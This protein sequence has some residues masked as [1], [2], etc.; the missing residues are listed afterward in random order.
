[1]ATADMNYDFPMSKHLVRELAKKTGLSPPPDTRGFMHVDLSLRVLA[2]NQE[3][4][5]TK[6]HLA[7]E[8]AR[9]TKY[10][11]SKFTAADARFTALEERINGKFKDINVKFDKVD[12]RLDN[13]E[14]RLDRF[15]HRFTQVDNTL[16]EFRTRFSQIDGQNQNGK[17]RRGVDAIYPIATFDGANG[18]HNPEYFPRTV[19]EFWKLQRPKNHAKLVYLTKF[20]EIRTYDQWD[21]SGDSSD[22]MDSDDESTRIYCPRPRPTVEAAVMSHPEEALRAVASK[23]GLKFDKIQAFFE[24][25]EEHSRRPT[26]RAEIRS[27]ADLKEITQPRKLIKTESSI[28]EQRVESSRRPIE[29]IVKEQ[30]KYADIENEP[31]SPSVK[32]SLSWMNSE[33]YREHRANAPT[34]Q[35]PRHPYRSPTPPPKMTELI[36]SNP[37]QMEGVESDGMTKAFYDACAAVEAEQSLIP[38]QAIVQT[39]DSSSYSD[40]FPRDPNEIP[41]Q[42]L[43]QKPSK[44]SKRSSRSS[45]SIS[46]HWSVPAY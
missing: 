38:I 10:I 15:D 43:T 3:N 41:T 22:D 9:Q 25:A 30:A 6:D 39:Q 23:L 40:R 11:D 5:V 31:S 29:E 28:I 24:K 14:E 21:D 18:I 1:M 16:A 7:G 13:I 27:R 19:K 8:F 4:L 34:V 37:E 20:Y 2:K 42:P 26:P 46:T 17:C 12:G 36:N 32:T 35:G 45:K 33:Q 44:S